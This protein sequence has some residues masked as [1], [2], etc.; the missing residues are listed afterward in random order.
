M[1]ITELGYE[2]FGKNYFENPKRTGK[3]ATAYLLQN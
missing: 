3:S 2:I 1:K